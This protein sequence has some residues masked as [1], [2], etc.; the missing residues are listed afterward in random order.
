MFSERHRK[1]RNP[2]SSNQL[3]VPHY[4]PGLGFNDSPA[5][6]IAAQFGDRNNEKPIFIS[7]RDNIADVITESQRKLGNLASWATLFS[8]SSEQIE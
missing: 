8:I 3:T 4:I 5:V 1:G 7:D 6:Q 2:G